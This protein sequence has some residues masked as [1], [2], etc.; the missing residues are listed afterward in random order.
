MIQ[1]GFIGAGGIAGTHAAA[2]A[3]GKG[4]KLAAVYDLDAGRAEDLAREYDAQACRSVEELIGFPGLNIIYILT[5]PFNHKELIIQVAEAGIAIMCE[6]PITLTLADADEAIAA[7]REHKV[8]LMVGQSHRYHPLAAQ[9]RH[10]LRAGDLGDFVAAWSHRLI[11]SEINPQNW[12]SKRA[13]GGGLTLQYAL[14]D[15]DWER[16]LAGEALQVA[17]NEYHTNPEVEIEDNLW[18]LVRFRNGGSGNVGISWTCKAPYTE[19]GVIGSKGNLR[20]VNQKLMVGKLADG[21]AIHEDLGAGYDWFDVFVRE[22]QDI[23]DRL[24]AGMSLAIPGEDG[25]ATLELGLA[26]QRAALTGELV[27]L[28]L[29]A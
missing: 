11:D 13:L 23:V 20:I 2:I 3:A 18:T 12:L 9:A 6:K 19:R 24:Q 4:G 25:R 29:S 8:Q 27:S 22:S 14:H 28:P 16:W 5:P 7:A 10:F 1:I 17:A 21:R 26:V 15:L